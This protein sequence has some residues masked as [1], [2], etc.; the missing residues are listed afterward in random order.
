VLDRLG[1]RP[2][3]QIY[4]ADGRPGQRLRVV[5]GKIEEGGGITG[6]FVT[7]G[8]VYVEDGHDDLVRVSDGDGQQTDLQ[9]TIPGRPTRDG[10][11]FIKAGVIDKAAGRV[12][13]QAHDLGKQLAWELPLNLTRPVLHLLLLDSDLKGRIYLGAEVGVEDAVT[14]E[15]GELATL[16]VQIDAQGKLTGTLTLPPTTADA[17]ETFRPLVVGDD[18]TIYHMV[19]TAQGLHISK[20]SF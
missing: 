10:K 7:A 17:A 14:H 6:L 16:V 13:V 9:E 4:D 5:G 15:M 11:L 3:V 12:Y 19:V 2:G 20:Y 18:G 8:G 1:Q